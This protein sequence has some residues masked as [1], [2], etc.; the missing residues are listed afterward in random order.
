MNCTL[1]V[2][3]KNSFWNVPDHY[4]AVVTSRC[5]SSIIY[6]AQTKDGKIVMLEYFFAFTTAPVPYSNST[7]KATTCNE[8]FIYLT[9]WTNSI[10]MPLKI[11]LR[12]IN[13]K[14]LLPF[15]VL[16]QVPS[17]MFHILIDAVSPELPEAI[18]LLCCKR[19]KECTELLWPINV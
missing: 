19:H 10:S 5:N 6:C 7:I 15:R 13:V 17:K 12:S 18:I 8:I 16:M 14:M 1:N 9:N 2:I 4:G 3:D 11:Y